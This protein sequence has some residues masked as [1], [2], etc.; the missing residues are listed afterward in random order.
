[1]NAATDGSAAKNA[2]GRRHVLLVLLRV[3]RV[4]A[5]DAVAQ[6][7]G[8]QVAQ[9]EP[10][11]HGEDQQ[12]GDHGAVHELH[13]V[14]DATGE[15]Q[16]GLE[17]DLEE[18]RAPAA[19]LLHRAQP[20][21]RRAHG[22]QQQEGQYPPAQPRRHVLVEVVRQHPKRDVLV[23]VHRLDVVQPLA[24]RPRGGLPG[25]GDHPARDEVAER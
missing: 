10:E 20:E 11:R 1:M 25:R 24:R 4:A 18:P 5:R 15:A 17:V 9:Q 14:D 12:R 19:Q 2:P 13:Q 7:S 22:E 3:Q 6:Q 23:R 8:T 21:D 16:D